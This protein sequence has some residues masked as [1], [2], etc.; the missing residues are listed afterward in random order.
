MENQEFDNTNEYVQQE[1]APMKPKSWLTEAILVLIIPLFC[2]NPLSLLGIV[3]IVYANQVNK[4]YFAGQYA[5]AERVSKNAKKWVLITLVA[6]LLWL[7]GFIV[8]AYITWC[9]CCFW[10]EYNSVRR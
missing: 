3:A 7:I 9:W 2:L 10:E 8:F 6:A 4:F 5:E 1:V